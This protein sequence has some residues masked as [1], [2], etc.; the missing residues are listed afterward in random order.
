ISGEI[1][2]DLELIFTGRCSQNLISNLIC[3][4]DSSKAEIIGIDFGKVPYC[5]ER[6]DSIRILNTGN[7]SVQITEISFIENDGSFEFVDVVTLPVELLS[8][9]YLA[10]AVRYLPQ[11]KVK[12]QN[13]AK[14]RAILMINGSESNFDTEII[15]ERV[16]PELEYLTEIDFGKLKPGEIKNID[17]EI[18]NRSVE[19]EISDVKTLTSNFSILSFTKTI[20]KNEKGLINLSFSSEII[21]EY[22]DEMTVYF[23]LGECEDSIKISLKAD[24]SRLMTIWANH[25]TTEVGIKGYEIPIFAETDIGAQIGGKK[26]KLNL[27]YLPELYYN[28]TVPSAQILS[29]TRDGNFESLIIEDTFPEITS[30]ETV[31]FH[32][33]GDVLFSPRMT[34]PIEVEFIE[35]EASLS[36]TTRDGSLTLDS[37]CQVSIRGIQQFTPTRMSI[38]PNPSDGE[39]KVSIGTQEEGSFSL[40]IFDVQ[41]VEVFRSEFTRNDRTFEQKDYNINTQ[42]LGNG[43]YT[44]HLTA[45]WTLLREQ[46]VVVR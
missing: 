27:R 5:E 38:S 13:F 30:K 39:L 34:T 10:F 14:V 7:P 15:G 44:I 31:L 45:P 33:K 17:F 11:D 40:I 41:G 28:V 4:F 1:N 3:K 24:V 12:S 46:V 23:S 6:I 21:G 26:Y 43:I 32:L 8:G 42:N 37:L 25:H 9:Q 19:I 35:S 29:K 18:L 16:I 2:T 22:A 20:Y 36:V